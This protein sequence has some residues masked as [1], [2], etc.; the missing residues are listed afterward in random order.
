[1]FEL[2]SDHTT[3]ELLSAVF[4]IVLL[5][6]VLSGDNAAVIGLAICHLPSQTRRKAAFFGAC[7]AIVLRIIFTIFATMLIAL[8]YF[9][10]GGGIVLFFIIW[11]LLRENSQETRS[12]IQPQKNFW[13]AVGIIVLADVS[14]A[15][16]NVLGVAGAAYGEP[17][18]VVFGLLVSI[19]I[20]V[21]GSSWLAGIMARWPIFL[22]LGAAVLLHTALLMILHDDALALWRY[23]GGHEQIVAWCI[24]TLLFI[25]GIFRCK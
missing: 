9:G 1:M 18:L 7:A 4:S 15:L 24:A 25:Y 17:L 10:L 5:D 20:L 3:S 19:P 13:K 6:L 12:S 22:W 21:L 11:R 14:M 8:P 2:L 16:D 23:T